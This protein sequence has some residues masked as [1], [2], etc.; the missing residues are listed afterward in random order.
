METLCGI[1][2]DTEVVQ[3]SSSVPS[4]PSPAD[5]CVPSGRTLVDWQCEFQPLWQH[6]GRHGDRTTDSRKGFTCGSLILFL[7]HVV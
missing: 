6:R 4:R 5:L 7:K 2:R 1:A 3:K